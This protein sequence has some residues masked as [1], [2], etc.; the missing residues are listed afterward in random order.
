MVADNAFHLVNA[1]G[2]NCVYE[3]CVI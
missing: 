3:S 1:G 2:D